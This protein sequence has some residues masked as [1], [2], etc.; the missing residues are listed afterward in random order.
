MYHIKKYIYI[1]YNSLI[2][3]LTF[4]IY[5][6]LYFIKNNKDFSYDKEFYY[7]KL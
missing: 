4:V 2:N 6:K 3:L 5:L 7:I 1:S